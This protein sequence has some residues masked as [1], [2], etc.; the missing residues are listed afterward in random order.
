MRAIF[1]GEFVYRRWRD[2]ISVEETL[3]RNIGDIIS[4]QMRWIGAGA[5]GT[6]GTPHGLN[7]NNLGA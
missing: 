1:N 6:V 7:C 2:F 4:V 3:F 5:D